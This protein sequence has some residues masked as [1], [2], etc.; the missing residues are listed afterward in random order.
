MGIDGAASGSATGNAGDDD[1]FSRAY[2]AAV[3]SSSIEDDVY[4][5]DTKLGQGVKEPV[6]SD[7]TENATSEP[8]GK[9]RAPK[10]EAP[11]ESVSEIAPPAHWDAQKR[12]AFGAL[13]PEAQKIV[14]DLA[15][16]FEADHTRK[17]TELAEDRKFATNVRSLINDTH[18]QQLRS[19]GMDETAGIAHLLRLNDYATSNPEGYVRWV[20]E[21]TGLDPRRLFPEYFAGQDEQQGYKPQQQYPAQSDETLRFLQTLAS[22]V[23]GMERS[24]E[25]QIVRQADRAID[26]FKNDVDESGA[27]RYPHFA[28]VEPLMTE[29]LTTPKY[30]AIEDFGERL[31]KAYDAAVYMDPDVRTQIVDS[32]VQKRMRDEQA[33]ADVAKARRAQA[34]VRAAPTGAPRAKPNS[35]DD[36]LSNAMST[37]GVA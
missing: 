25:Q 27:A 33:K 30:Q 21:N 10:T 19:A 28:R 5:P 4:A 6:V 23:E 35:I 24:G 3:S 36:A 2:D 34:P 11:K 7:S 37:I 1:A 8:A 9:A 15:K 20:V 29:L 17:T 22:K 13:P 31:A 32:D 16:G 12:E 26:R 18:R 14:N